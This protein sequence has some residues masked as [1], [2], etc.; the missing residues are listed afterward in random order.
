MIYKFRIVSDEVNNFKREIDINAADTFMDLKNAICDSVG[1]DKNQMC[2]F[3]ICNDN[4]EKMKEVA[5]EEMGF[6]SDQDVALMDDTDLDS[7]IEDEGQKLIFV[8]DYLTDRCFYMDMKSS[9]SG[10]IQDPVCTLSVGAAP[11]QFTDIDE[12]AKITDVSSSIEDIDTDA[13]FYG[14]ESYNPD[15]FDISNYDISEE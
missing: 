10:Q 13:D 8:F 14:S 15:E 4:W 1:Y 5:M 7:L 11:S 9:R 2:S 3:F 12:F 6:D